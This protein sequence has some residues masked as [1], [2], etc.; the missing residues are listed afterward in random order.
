ML[1]AST[2]TG[3]GTGYNIQ[4][5]RLLFFFDFI[6]VTRKWLFIGLNDIKYYDQIYD[7][8]TGFW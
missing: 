1:H 5:T 8:I 7:N 3:T 2:G 6:M 4:A